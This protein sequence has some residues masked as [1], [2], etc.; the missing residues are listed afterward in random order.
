M[1][2][3]RPTNAV[4]QLVTIGVS[5]AMVYY[6]WREWKATEGDLLKYKKLL[7]REKE[8]RQVER[9]GR[10]SVQQNKRK[11]IKKQIVEKGFNFNPI[12]HVESPF[13]DRRGTPRQPNLVRAACGRIKFDK[14]II[15]LE[16]F[17]ELQEF[18]HVWVLWVF[19]VSF[20]HPEPVHFTLNMCFIRKI[21]MLVPLS[22]L[23]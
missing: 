14:R 12:G 20:V 16:H 10:I 21:R 23:K 5:A 6:F 13:P 7:E 17:K 9:K 15:Q 8:L 4:Q 2:F 19:H 3:L 11:D 18:S 1:D 22:L